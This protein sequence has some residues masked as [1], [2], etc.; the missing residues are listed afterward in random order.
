MCTLI[1]G[2][3]LEKCLQNCRCRISRERD[4]FRNL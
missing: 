3:K 1:V 4:Y 2:Y